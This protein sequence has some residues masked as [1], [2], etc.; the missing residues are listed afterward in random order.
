MGD[1]MMTTS[2]FKY[3]LFFLH[4]HFKKA[5]VALKM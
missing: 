5:S 4:H 3:S 2:I 1:V